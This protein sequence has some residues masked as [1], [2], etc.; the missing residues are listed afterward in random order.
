MRL[1][2]PSPTELRRAREIGRALSGVTT[3]FSLSQFSAEATRLLDSPRF[4]VQRISPRNSGYD[5]DFVHP[6]GWH[7]AEVER[8]RTYLR[9]SPPGFAY[10]D[11]ARPEPAQRNVVLRTASV[12]HGKAPPIARELFGPLLGP[13]GNDQLRVLVCDGPVLLAWAGGFRRRAH[14]P[15]EQALLRA[16]VP[17]LR[18]RLLVELRLATDKLD[19]AALATAVEAISAAAV[20]VRLEGGRARLAH[21]N[22]VAR[23]QYAHLPALEEEWADAVQG[24]AAR[25]LWSVTPLTERGLPQ[26]FLLLARTG[27][28]APRE[29][30]AVAA[31][32]WGLTP[33]QAQVLALLAQGLSNKE[34][35]R[36]LGR[37][38]STVEMHLTGILLRSSASSRADLVARLWSEEP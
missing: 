4:A 12:F 33:R 22:S 9:A 16:L 20:L 36:E 1:E 11:P 17:S 2:R 25:A 14:G 35:G 27:V 6:A 8:I 28:R 32:R 34:I 37:S 18:R 21:A 30:V 19:A 3:G 7:S 29:R 13:E 24:G 38:E 10:F 15:R 26:Y 23:A 5:F 31:H